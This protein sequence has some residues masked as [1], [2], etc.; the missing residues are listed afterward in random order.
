[1]GKKLVDAAWQKQN[2]WTREGMA[3]I[4]VAWFSQRIT[5]AQSQWRRAFKRTKIN[6][7]WA[8]RPI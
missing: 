2:S 4:M 7:Q 3:G 8:Y 5:I 6:R 1:M